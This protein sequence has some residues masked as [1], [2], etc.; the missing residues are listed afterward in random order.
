M[1]YQIYE[2]IVNPRLAVELTII[3]FNPDISNQDLLNLREEIILDACR[4]IPNNGQMSAYNRD[5]YLYSR[6]CY[7]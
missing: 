5:Y 3:H 2:K 6:K 1:Y 7:V 4:K